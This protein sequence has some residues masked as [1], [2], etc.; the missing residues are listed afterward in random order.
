MV[1]FG[2]ASMMSNKAWSDPNAGVAYGAILGS[3]V[4]WL[5]GRQEEVGIPPKQ[6]EMFT[7]NPNASLG[8]IILLPGL[9][10][11]V[12]IVGLGLGVWTVRRR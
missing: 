3:S 4:A 2:D 9:I 1:V 6:A 8:Q 12:S 11:L 7:L 10:S 5:R